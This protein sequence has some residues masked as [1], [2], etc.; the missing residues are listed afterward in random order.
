MRTSCKLTTDVLVVGS[1][2]SGFWAAMT[3]REHVQDVLI[4][5]KGPRDWGGIGYLSGGD[6]FAMTPDMDREKL[7]DELVYFYDGL[8]DQE[9]LEDI[10]DESYDRFTAYERMGHEFV[11][12]ANGKLMGIPQRGLEHMCCFHSKPYG[13]GG[14]NFTRELVREVEKRDIRRIGRIMITD[15]VKN[16][17][18]VCGAVGFFT[19]SGRPV[20]IEA[21][22]VILTTNIGGWKCSY[23]ANSMASGAAELAL[24]AGVALRN[25]EF[26]MVWNLPKLFSWEGQTGLLPKGACFRNA[27]GEDFMQRYSPRYGAKADPHYN[28]RGM[29]HE[30]RE[31]R[32]PIYFDTSA[33]SPQDVQIMRPKGGW[34]KLNDDK[35]MALGINFFRQKTE[36]MPQYVHSFGGMNVNRDYGTGVPG[37]YAAGRACSVDPGVYLGGWSLCVVAVSGFKVGHLA[38]RYAASASHQ[39]YD[40]PLA[41]ELAGR[42]L[43]RLGRPGLPPKDVVRALQEIMAPVDVC[44]LKSGVGLS[45][46]L[47]K[48]MSLR[49]EVLGRMVASDP[50][51][52][53]KCVEAEGIA[54]LTEAYL[55]SSLM[56]K[57]SRSGH[58]RED[59]PDR[60]PD[61]PYWIL[62]ERSRNEM[63]SRIVRV[64]VETYRIQPYKYYM[65]AFNF[66]RKKDG[67]SIYKTND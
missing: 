16:G 26:L 23:L 8:C 37:L 2:F 4:V 45:R 7:L 17:D 21:K 65:D 61:G 59:F 47:D 11:R 51:Q 46:S 52:L 44:I 9:V 10:L 20:Y 31:G 19:Q 60:D 24:N 29:A 36:W 58:Y 41:Q 50:Q 55:R 15:V 14:G 28:V 13:K 40:Q 48:L 57:E 5:D 12:D 33:M 18:T 63:T 49:A 56:R 53:V 64:P 25:C 62:A 32:G 66:P 67:E 54:D 42:R 30:V 35:L 39:A 3:A 22:A 34:M 27:L 1:G 6:L 43:S 38:G